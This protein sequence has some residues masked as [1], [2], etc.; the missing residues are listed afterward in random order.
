MS[1]FLVETQHFSS[2]VPSQYEEESCTDVQNTLLQNPK[3]NLSHVTPKIIN[4]SSYDLSKPEIS[5]LSKGAKYCPTPMQ[6]NLLELRVDILEFL[7]K[8]QLLDMF[9]NNNTPANNTISKSIVKKNRALLSHDPVGIRF[10]N[11]ISM[12]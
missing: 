7:R 4:I 12:K 5:L 2:P 10:Y 8:I 11:Q 9:G 1:E 6:N 3:N